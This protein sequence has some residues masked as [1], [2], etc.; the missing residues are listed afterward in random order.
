MRSRHLKYLAIISLF[1]PL[2]GCVNMAIS[3]ANVL[4][5]HHGI[6]RTI[7]NH[8]IAGE[9]EGSLK[10]HHQFFGGSDIHAHVF[11]YDVLLVGTVRS[12]EQKEQAE[13]LSRRQPLVQHVYNALELRK[14]PL[15]V[16]EQ[17]Y[18]TWITSKIKAKFVSTNSLDP[19][20]IK[21]VTQNKIV[22][23]M[24]RADDQQARTA[25]SIAKSTDGV[26]EVVSY[27]HLIT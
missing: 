12:E 7:N 8:H 13:R 2:A 10:K 3:S 5:Q 27:L 24:G 20:G 6:M 1:S 16:S 22:Y 21:I 14:F 26:L 17:T 9:I 15:T 11:Y 18:D 23:L 4:Y 25:R 19:D